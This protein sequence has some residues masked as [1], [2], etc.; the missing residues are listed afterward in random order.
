M[1]LQIKFKSLYNGWWG[2]GKYF[3]SLEENLMLNM[4]I[5]NTNRIQRN[6]GI[7][8]QSRIKNVFGKRNNKKQ[9]RKGSWLIYKEK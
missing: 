2:F 5:P 1:K 4:H 9:L 6:R 7:R 3:I 8:T